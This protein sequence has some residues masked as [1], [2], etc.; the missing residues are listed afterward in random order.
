MEKVRIVL[1][2]FFVY[3]LFIADDVSAQCRSYSSITQKRPFYEV[4]FDCAKE[5]SESSYLSDGR[6]YRALLT[7]DQ[8]SDFYITFYGGNTYRIAACTDIQGGQVFFTVKDQKGNSLYSNKDYENAPYWD[9]EFASTIDCKIFVQLT[10]E[11]QKLA[12]QSGGGEES[13]T[14]AETSDTT[15]KT[16]TG[17]ASGKEVSVCA[18]LVVGYKQE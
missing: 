8:V 9:L 16:E 14:E 15:K 12:S 18:V 5:Y 2:A 11:T 3:G 1:L 4:E 6:N 17:A 10:P 7:G 13:K